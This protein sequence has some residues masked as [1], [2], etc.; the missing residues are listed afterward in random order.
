MLAWIDLE[1]TGLDPK[2]DSV[3]EVACIITTDDLSEVARF[4]RVTGE[5]IRHDLAKVHPVVI[6]MHSKNGLWVE[7]M[8]AGIERRAGDGR[9]PEFRS[10]GWEID[11]VDWALSKFIRDTCFPPQKFDGSPPDKYYPPQLAGSTISFDREFLRHHLPKTLAELHYRN[12]DTSTLNEMAR[13]YWPAVYS[14]RPA[15]GKD[16]AHRAVDDILVSIETA[17]YYRTALTPTA[18]PSDSTDS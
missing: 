5:A 4:S 18:W 16:G 1:T 2:A 9:L 17:R 7:S 10:G 8:M 12:L 13:R 11:R 15:A 14:G 3:L 6:D